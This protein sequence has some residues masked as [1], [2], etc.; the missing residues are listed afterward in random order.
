MFPA[1]GQQC[2]FSPSL[3][4]DKHEGEGRIF[5]QATD[6]GESFHVTHEGEKVKNYTTIRTSKGAVTFKKGGTK[7]K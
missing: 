3:W 4:V 5:G 6:S 2:K 1:Y 7:K